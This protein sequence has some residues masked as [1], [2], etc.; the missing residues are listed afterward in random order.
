MAYFDD[1]G[2]DDRESTYR[3]ECESNLYYSKHNVIMLMIMIMI[4]MMMMMMMMVIR[5]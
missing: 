1:D 4:M 2:D 5:W 3:D